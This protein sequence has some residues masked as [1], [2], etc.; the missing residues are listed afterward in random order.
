MMNFSKVLQTIQK[1][2]SFIIVTHVGPDPDG[3]P[4]GTGAPGRWGHLEHARRPTHG[5][6]GAGAAPRPLATEGGILGRAHGR[7]ALSLLVP[8]EPLRHRA[9]DDDSAICSSRAP[10]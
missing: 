5:R 4:Q 1:Y 3:L 8:V 9:H 2:N 6:L 10:G 7:R